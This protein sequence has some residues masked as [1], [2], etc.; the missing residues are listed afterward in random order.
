MSIKG[1]MVAGPP[2]I[3]D[4]SQTDESKA[5]YIK[6]KPDMQEYLKKT[7]GNMTGALS[8][9]T[10]TE[11]DHGATK[12]YVDKA[13]KEVRD[14]ANEAEKEKL[15]FLYTVVNAAEFTFDFPDADYPYRAA[16]TLPGVTA[17]M[18]PEVT[19]SVADLAENEFA[20]V[21]ECYNGGVYIYAADKPTATVVIPTIICWR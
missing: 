17:S 7:G 3:P 2:M 8:M 13:V 5:D 4:F 16:V 11:E 12:G 6:N 9:V 20:P 10:P 18:I 15:K 19:F 14:V 21:A 1:N